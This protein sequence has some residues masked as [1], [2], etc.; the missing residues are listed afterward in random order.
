MTSIL[1]S[2]TRTGTT[3]TATL[4][5]EYRTSPEDLWEAITSPE[6]L[7][8]WFG[9]VAIDG[10][11]Y[12]IAF[13]PDDETQRTGGDILACEPPRRLEITW[14]NAG[15][16]YASNVVIKLEPS[17]DNTRLMLVHSGLDHNS[18]AGH[19]A[20][21]DIYVR[22]LVAHLDGQDGADLWGEWPGLRDAYLALVT[23]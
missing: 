12:R 20:G 5:H 2:L 19:A 1:G 3:G 16:D 18:D 6:R 13:S 21:W 10:E 22:T 9:E 11:T 4:T 23:D 8:R 14:Q 17:G 15:E 7:R